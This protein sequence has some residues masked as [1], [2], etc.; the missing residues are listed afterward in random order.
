VWHRISCLIEPIAAYII[1]SERLE[2][3]YEY[4][5]IVLIILGLLTL[6]IPLLMKKKFHFSKILGGFI[7]KLINN[8]TFAIKM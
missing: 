3:Y 7:S 1:L 8:E 6:K 2:Y 5:G 4:I